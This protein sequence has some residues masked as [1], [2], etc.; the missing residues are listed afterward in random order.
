MA[1]DLIFGNASSDRMFQ[2]REGR[3]LDVERRVGL[4]GTKKSIS[5]TEGIL[6][7]VKK[8]GSGKTKKYKA[9]QT[10]D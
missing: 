1:R 10:E 6:Q 2:T 3:K 5:H 8:Y 4:A 7:A 9:Y